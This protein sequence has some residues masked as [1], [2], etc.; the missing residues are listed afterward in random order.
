MP[1]K[2][3]QQT[4]KLD[5]DARRNRSRRSLRSVLELL[6]LDG[7]AVRTADLVRRALQRGIPARTA[8]RY[9]RQAEALGL[10]QSRRDDGRV[11]WALA[12][13]WR[14]PLPM[15]LAVSELLGVPSTLQEATIS[16]AASKPFADP[17]READL[18]AFFRSHARLFVSLAYNLFRGFME[19]PS[20]KDAQE[21]AAF[22]ADQILWRW[23]SAL[24]ILAWNRRPRTVTEW[25]GPL[26]AAI[27]PLLRAS[28]TSPHVRGE[29][30]PNKET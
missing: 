16:D 15:A 25:A 10:A 29:A 12:L 24:A 6:P 28:H 7:G 27:S 30:L 14:A 18:E 5:F 2:P 11:T 4:R 17:G 8:Y 26:E 23:L 1:R 9:L 20:K 22:V 3:K 13:E 21:F 19:A